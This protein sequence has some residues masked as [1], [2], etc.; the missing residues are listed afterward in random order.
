MSLLTP[1]K[2]PVKVYRWDDVGAPALDKTA[3]CVMTIFKACL[4]TGYG[5]KTGAGWTMPFEDTAAGVKVL[6]SEIS[7]HTD[8]YLRCS[9]DTG[10]EMAAQVYL[11][12]TD[13]N[14]GDLKL[15]CA[16]PF[17][18]AKANSTGKWL[19]IA[20]PRSFWFFCDQRFS[21]GVATKTGAYFYAGDI[22]NA[23]SGQDA[24]YLTHTGGTGNDGAYSDIFGRNFGGNIDKTANRYLSGKL[25][26]GVDVVFTVD[27]TS[28]ADNIAAKTTMP[29]LTP[30]FV[31]A[32]G[33][34]YILSSA[35]ATLSA[36]TADNFDAVTAVAD[37]A[38]TMI[39]HGTGG[40]YSG[41]IYINTDSWSY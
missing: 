32:S 17:K 36:A 1:I 27:V 39:V 22:K 7:P 38:S 3:G 21:D 37:A 4:V 34:L 41:N 35:H 9:A 18:Y 15:Q 40:R 30:V 25:L 24:V 2:V 8:F 19:L 33:G 31:T 29:H 20:S 23:D 16:T 26:I 13:V 14:T 11:N 6:R 12:M 5:T 28:A 10:T